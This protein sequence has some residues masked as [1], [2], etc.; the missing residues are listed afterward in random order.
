MQLS[1]SPSASNPGDGVLEVVLSLSHERGKNKEQNKRTKQ[2]KRK[3]KPQNIPSS[4]AK[5][6]QLVLQHTVVVQLLSHQRNRKK[7]GPETCL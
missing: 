2:N 3:T 7:K 5:Q 4:N 1:F 6:F